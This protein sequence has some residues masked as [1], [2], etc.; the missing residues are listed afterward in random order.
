MYIKNVFHTFR[1]TIIEFLL[2]SEHIIEW[3]R[4]VL[5]V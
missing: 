1:N 5:L 4:V 2:F 3:Y